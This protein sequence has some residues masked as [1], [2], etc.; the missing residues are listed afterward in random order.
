MANLSSAAVARL[1]SEIA[2]LR[3]A[4]E[5]TVI[6]QCGADFGGAGHLLEWHAKAAVNF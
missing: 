6:G 1:V 4:L 3:S 2:D 5:G